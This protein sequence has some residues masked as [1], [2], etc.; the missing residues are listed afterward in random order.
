MATWRRVACCISKVARVQAHAPARARA[1][2]F[3]HTQKYVTRVAFSWQQWF[4]ERASMVHYTYIASLVF[5]PSLSHEPRVEQLC[6]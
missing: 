3:T 1:F 5:C 4:C 2:V 6:D